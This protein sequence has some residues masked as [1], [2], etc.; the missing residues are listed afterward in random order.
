MDTPYTVK[1]TPLTGTR[2]VHFKCPKCA[3]PINFDLEDAGKQEL[4]PS[5]GSRCV[6]PGISDLSLE[7]ERLAAE[8]AEERKRREKQAEKAEEDAAKEHTRAL[9]AQRDR[10]DSETRAK[11][12][13]RWRARTA[14]LNTW[15]TILLWISLV[16]FLIALLLVLRVDGVLGWAIAGL[17]DSCILFGVICKAAGLLGAE[18]SRRACELEDAIRTPKD[19]TR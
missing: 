4:C 15:G 7:R 13:D 5:C 14:G 6:V 19:S 2:R 16:L 12:T 9:Q 3:D 1:R 17:A 11:A 10:L 8:K 18:I